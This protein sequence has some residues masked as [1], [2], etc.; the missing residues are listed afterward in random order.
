MNFNC[1]IPHT[2]RG[3]KWFSF[4]SNIPSIS[5]P[6]L[7]DDHVYTSSNFSMIVSTHSGNQL[8]AGPLGQHF[9]GPS[10]LRVWKYDLPLSKS[11]SVN[12]PMKDPALMYRLMLIGCLRHCL[13]CKW[14]LLIVDRLFLSPCRKVKS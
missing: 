8:R 3:H 6:V 4:S 13:Q 11:R 9:N 10:C 2:P 1:S 12:R 7:V 5:V 14:Q